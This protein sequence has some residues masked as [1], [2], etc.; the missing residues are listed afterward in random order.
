MATNTSTAVNNE[1]PQIRIA[2]CLQRLPIITR[3]KNELEKLYD[4]LQ[5]QLEFEHSSLSD[6]EVYKMKMKNMREKLKNDEDND[7][8]KK[9]VATLDS[10]YQVLQCGRLLEGY[11]LAGW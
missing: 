11:R 9:E 7:A 6:Y 1:I 3:E 5:E 10:E 2:I 8:L 4:E